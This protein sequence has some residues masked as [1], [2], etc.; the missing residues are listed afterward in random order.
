MR[1]INDKA[2]FQIQQGVL[3]DLANATLGGAVDETVVAVLGHMLL[4]VLL[5][6]HS[7]IREDEIEVPTQ[8]DPH[9]DMAQ[10]PQE[11]HI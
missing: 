7:R 10:P 11:K 1:I 6:D 2:N 4:D 8:G 5:G 3:G 9:E